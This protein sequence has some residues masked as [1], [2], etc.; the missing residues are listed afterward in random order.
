MIYWNHFIVRLIRK[1]YTFNFLRLL[2]I[3]LI[4][5]FL[6]NCYID[7]T[8]A[9]ISLAEAE[10][11]AEN[12]I[13]GIVPNF[14]YE[15]MSLISG[16]FG[17]FKTQKPVEV[18]LWLA[19]ELKKKGK[20]TII[21][22][23][24]LDEEIL[25]NLVELEKESADKSNELKCKLPDFYFF[26]LSILLLHYSQDQ[27]AHSTLLRTLIEDLFELRKKKL[28][29]SM[30][31]IDFKERRVRKIEN[32]TFFEINMIRGVYQKAYEIGYSIAD[33]VN[34]KRYA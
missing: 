13:I 20:C 4:D 7:D 6:L 9:S 27:I 15:K 10:F 17:P 28:F 3:N 29:I 1:E 5:W 31:S 12:Q 2:F 11:F 22:P 25:K 8:I 32:I 14:N 19:L 16:N 24:W 33:L 26:E 30:K 34:I 18:P 21:V 23:N